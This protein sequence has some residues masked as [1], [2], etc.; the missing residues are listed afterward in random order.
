[1][2]FAENQNIAGFDNEDKSLCTTAR[3]LVENAL[4]A[5]EAMPILPDIYVEVARIMEEKFRKLVGADARGRID[6]SLYKDVES[7]KETKAI[8]AKERC[9]AKKRE[10]S[11]LSQEVAPTTTKRSGGRAETFRIAVHNNGTDMAH[12]EVPNKMCRVLA[13]TKYCVQ[14]SEGSLDSNRKW[15]SF[16]RR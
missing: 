3:E 13:G 2:F 15:R 7:T 1:M 16:H 12:D 14:Q 5:A 6:E 9:E 4:Y 10:K 8:E 11:G